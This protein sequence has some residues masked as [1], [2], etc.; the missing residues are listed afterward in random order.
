MNHL[1]VVAFLCCPINQPLLSS[2]SAVV[3]I[4]YDGLVLIHLVLIHLFCLYRNTSHCNHH[5]SSK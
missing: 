1:Y 4:D 3:G 5:C 2:F